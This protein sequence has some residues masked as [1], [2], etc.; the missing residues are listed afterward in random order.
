MEHVL[1][2]KVESL[3]REY[4]LNRIT[5]EFT[6]REAGQMVIGMGYDRGWHAED[7][8]ELRQQQGLLTFDFNQGTDRIVLVYRTPYFLTGLVVS[9]AFL[10]GLIAVA[11][12]LSRRQNRAPIR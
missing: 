12:V 3:K 1:S 7:G 9:V 4:T 5:Y 8:R 10:I 2:G 6:A 11:T